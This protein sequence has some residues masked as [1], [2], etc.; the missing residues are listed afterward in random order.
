MKKVIVLGATGTIGRN[1]LSVIDH[2]GGGWQ[3]DLIT[4]FTRKTELEQL[5]K[6]YGARAFT[7]DPETVL[8]EIRES[9][10]GI[11]VN[12]IAGAAGL[13]PSFE[14][15]RSGKRLALANKE[16]VVMAGALLKAEAARSGAEIIPV[17]SEHAALFELRRA[18]DPASIRKLI[19]TASGGAFRD[20]PAEDLARVTP[21]QALRHPTWKMGPK[22]TVDSATMANKGL[23]VIEA[24]CLFDC[25]PDKIEVFIH[26]QSR[27]HALIQTAEGTFTAQI[28]APDMRIP[29]A[30]I[31]TAEGTFTAQISAPDMRIPIQNALTYPEKA[32]APCPDTDLT[33]EALTFTRPDPRKY[34]MLPLAFRA[35]E[36][37]LS[38]AIAY[39]AANEVAVAAFLA[40]RLPF[41]S[42]AR[43][44]E[45]VLNKPLPP[46][47]ASLKY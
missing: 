21:E 31:Q 29:I 5:A 47:P 36:A 7:T 20:T 8:K 30:L 18:A 45:A 40:H 32:A 22:I 23:E 16:T 15:V 41:L 34:P 38:A 4:A 25:P 2:L 6:Q 13:L 44:T 17:D 35:A 46:A 43:L 19:I 42:I 37:G 24:V 3:T 9:D 39:N 10:A 26:P 14:A 1:T 27:I 28:S 12:G 33:A 11:V